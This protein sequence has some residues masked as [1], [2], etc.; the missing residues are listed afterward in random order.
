MVF[1]TQA[2]KKL[3]N[4]RFVRDFLFY[5]C[6]MFLIKFYVN[7]NYMFCWKSFSYAFCMNLGLIEFLSV[8]Y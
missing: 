2:K 7:F 6:L 3:Q 1:F 5:Y 8:I 4:L